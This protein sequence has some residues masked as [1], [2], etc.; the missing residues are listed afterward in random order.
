MPPG[1]DFYRSM[2]ELYKCEPPEHYSKHVRSILY[3]DTIVMAI[4][5][6]GMEIGTSE[7][8]F[9]IAGG[10]YDK[11]DPFNYFVFESHRKPGQ[12]GVMHV[13]ASKFDDE[14]AHIMVGKMNRCISLHG[15]KDTATGYPEGSKIA[16]MGGL[17]TRLRDLVMTELVKAGFDARVTEDDM[18]NGD[19]PNNVANLTKNREGCY[20]IELTTSLRGS[21]FSDNTAGGR[22]KSQT[23]D[24]WRFVEAVRRGLARY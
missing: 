16:W 5:G 24:F 6:G 3:S 21:F 22:G 14:A 18:L 23:E 8:A 13:T 15:S 2:T 1:P 9:G 4:H 17:N 12:N 19:H 11:Q 10:V 7:L 20:Q